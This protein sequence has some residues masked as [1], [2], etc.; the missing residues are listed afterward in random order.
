MVTSALSALGSIL[1]TVIS[2][3]LPTL[4]FTGCSG[5]GHSK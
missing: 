4:I 3:E 2:S 1:R 5:A